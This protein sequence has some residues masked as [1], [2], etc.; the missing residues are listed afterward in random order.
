MRITTGQERRPW[1]DGKRF[2]PAVFEESVSPAKRLS[3]DAWEALENA[4][5]Q[6]YAWRAV[7]ATAT[8]TSM[9]ND[10]DPLLSEIWNHTYMCMEGTGDF[11][12][13]PQYVRDAQCARRVARALALMAF[14]PEFLLA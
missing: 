1:V 6:L 3:A 7:L 12:G 9:Q 5:R 10:G 4:E 2:V 14:G 11:D 13:L 8:P